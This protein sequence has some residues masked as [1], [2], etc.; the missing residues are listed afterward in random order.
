MCLGTFAESWLSGPCSERTGSKALCG[1]AGEPVIVKSSLVRCWPGSGL[2]ALDHS[3]W[4]WGLCVCV[5]M[6]PQICCT[7][8]ASC[9]PAPH[10][11]FP[12]CGRRKQLPSPSCLPGTGVTRRPDPDP[13]PE[14]AEPARLFC[15]GPQGGREV[16]PVVEE[17]SRC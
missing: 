6:S 15:Q 9:S 10:L 7:V 17:A 4:R 3:G 13:D 12:M 11:S 2:A 16:R 14:W 5:Q 8:K 1:G